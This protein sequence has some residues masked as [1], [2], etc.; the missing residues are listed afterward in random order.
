MAG[1]A[2]VLRQ[3]LIAA[4]TL[5][6]RPE[7]VADGLTLLRWLLDRETVHAHLSVTPAAGAGLRDRGPAYDQ[8]PIEVAAM[9]D[10]C[11]RAALATGDSRWSHGI[12]LATQWFAG[13]NDS[14]VV[15]WDPDTGG[16]Y[17]GLQAAGP[18]LNQ[19][20]ESTLALISTLQHAHRLAAG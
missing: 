15:M 18:N 20:A 2:S 17:D 16:G 7:V 5:L 10:A 8:Q 6:E 4:G 9:A 12:D 1:A 3:A 19:G 13:D 11:A 14:E